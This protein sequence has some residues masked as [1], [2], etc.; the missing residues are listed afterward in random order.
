MKISKLRVL[1]LISLGFLA[2]LVA[3]GTTFAGAN[4]HAVGNDGGE[5][6]IYRYGNQIG[7]STLEVTKQGVVEVANCHAV[8]G[9]E[10]KAPVQLTAKE[11]AYLKSD[12]AE[13][14]SGEIEKINGTE[15]TYGS[16]SGSMLAYTAA[17]EEVTIRTIAR[18]PNGVS[19]GGKKNLDVVSVNSSSAARLIE[20]FVNRYLDQHKMVED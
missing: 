6:I 16:A 8:G 10:N 15:T 13:A 19:N 3:P 9:C 1:L 5:L 20:D 2:G 7:W 12:I 4:A 11:F 18:N 17:N 14:A